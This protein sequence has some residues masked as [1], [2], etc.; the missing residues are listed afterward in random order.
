MLSYAKQGRQKLRTLLHIQDWFQRSHVI[1]KISSKKSIYLLECFISLRPIILWHPFFP[2]SIFTSVPSM[3]NYFCPLSFCLSFSLLFHPPVSILPLDFHT[4]A[5]PAGL[6]L[7]LSPSLFALVPLHF[8]QVT[9]ARNTKLQT[10]QISL[11]MTPN[12]CRMAP[13]VMISFSNLCCDIFASWD[14]FVCL[15]ADMQNN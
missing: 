10:T 15:R 2:L 5:P 9:K 14:V 11:R 6:C 8:Y 1:L 13:T 12:L 7:S 3:L 4:S